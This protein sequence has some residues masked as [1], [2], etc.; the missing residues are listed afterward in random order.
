MRRKKD[1]NGN[2]ISATHCI[3]VQALCIYILLAIFVDFVLCSFGA[4]YMGAL[5]N[6]LAVMLVTGRYP[7]YLGIRIHEGIFWSG[8]FCSFRD[9]KN[10]ELCR[11]MHA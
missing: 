10:S 7:K 4:M 2:A 1:T 9:L 11:V 5:D 8:I 6:P 3:Y